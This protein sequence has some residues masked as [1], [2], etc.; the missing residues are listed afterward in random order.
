MALCIILL[1]VILASIF[2]HGR[3]YVSNIVKFRKTSITYDKIN[4]SICKWA[5]IVPLKILHLLVC[6]F[7]GFL[8]VNYMNIT[9]KFTKKLNFER[10]FSLLLSLSTILLFSLVKALFSSNV[11]FPLQ[12]RLC[13]AYP[14]FQH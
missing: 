3:R 7:Q 9:N 2:K 12:R 8:H 6:S 13:T 10:L 11:Y 5:Q 4:L 1:S 14:V